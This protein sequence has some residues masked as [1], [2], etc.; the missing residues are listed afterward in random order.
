MTAFTDQL[1]G[2]TLGELLEAAKAGWWPSKTNCLTPEW[3]TLR[4][5]AIQTEALK[6][7]QA[8]NLAW[9]T[10]MHD[11]AGRGLPYAEWV[12][13]RTAA[14]K[15]RIRA[16]KLAQSN[17]R[18]KYGFRGKRSARLIRASVRECYARWAA[19]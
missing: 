15:A 14:L 5:W 18:Y 8:E 13:Q 1:A 17:L 12:E 6:T 11:L 3:D 19:E 7:D 9:E 4:N 2:A 10:A 16:R